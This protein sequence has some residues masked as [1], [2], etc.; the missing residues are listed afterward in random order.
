MVNNNTGMGSASSVGGVN[1]TRPVVYDEPL[2]MSGPYDLDE[3][4]KAVQKFHADRTQQGGN[5]HEATTEKN[6][7]FV[8]GSYGNV[9]HPVSEA[10][11][12]LIM[13]D[14]KR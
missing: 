9:S 5:P 2:I 8:K 7:G 4:N 12:K 14:R 6:M 11:W 10:G 3:Y 1:K 13:A